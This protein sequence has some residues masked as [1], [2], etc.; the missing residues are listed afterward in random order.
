MTEKIK[1]LV[2]DEGDSLLEVISGKLNFT[3]KI[4]YQKISHV[5]DLVLALDDF[6]PHLI[7]VNEELSS[8]ES[9]SI[10]AIAKKRSSE[11]P[12]IIFFDE[13][14]KIRFVKKQLHNPIPQNFEILLDSLTEIVNNEI[15]KTKTTKGNPGGLNNLM[16]NKFAFIS[17]YLFVLN[18]DNIVESFAKKDSATLTESIKD[19]VGR[20]LE[21]VLDQ[22]FEKKNTFEV[23]YEITMRNKFEKEVWSAKGGGSICYHVRS[24]LLNDRQKIV[25]IN[26]ITKSKN[27]ELMLESRDQIIN[28]LPFAV[29]MLDL[30]DQI[31]NCNEYFAR[32]AASSV[33]TL[34]AKYFEDVI[35]L[36]FNGLSFQEMKKQL[37]ENG[38]WS[39][40]VSIVSGIFKDR[41]S[42]EIFLVKMPVEQITNY[43]ITMMQASG[44]DDKVADVNSFDDYYSIIQQIP[45]GVFVLQNDSVVY[46]NN[47]FAKMLGYSDNDELTSLSF[48]NLLEDN[49]KEKYLE[50]SG[51]I[52]SFEELNH[53]AEFRFV[54]RNGIN[55]VFTNCK[56]SL[57]QHSSGLSIIGM[58]SDLTERKL[59]EEIK[60]GSPEKEFSSE[61][62]LRG[63]AHD[64]RTFLNQI[65]GFADILKEQVKDH[66]DQA[67]LIYAEHIFSSGKKLLDLLEDAP[68]VSE[69]AVL[70]AITPKHE[71]IDV[72]PVLTE[73]IT[74][75]NESL[76]EK[77]IKVSL[78]SDTTVFAIADRRYLIDVLNRIIQNCIAMSSAG[79]ILVDCGYDSIKHNVYIRFKDNRPSIPEDIIEHLFDPVS[80]SALTM[81]EQLRETSITFSIIKRVLD[82]M[83]CKVVVHSSASKGTTI[84]IQLPLDEKNSETVNKGPNVYYTISPDVIYLNDMR[85]YIL[86]IE[87]DPGSS[88]MLEITLKNVARLELAANGKE[89]ITI[90]NSKYEQ[91]IFFD[92]VLI[93]IGLPPP[94]NGITLSHAIKSTFVEYQSIPFI[95]ETAFA[96]EKDREKILSAGFAGFMAKPIDRRYLIKTI[97]SAI[98]KRHGDEEPKYEPYVNPD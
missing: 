86:I 98:R 60:K 32:L 91:G 31:A 57:M 19:Y 62:P 66:P 28:L 16:L 22:F 97:A 27:I 55:R 52:N 54:H 24:I 9:L 69:S 25:S 49:E 8:Y 94:W 50:I 48:V 51:Q 45:E 83:D 41:Y 34:S 23:Q 77:K 37:F 90:I 67:S 70:T 15:G 89:A 96:L 33:E 4:E 88:K 85:P 87:D 7:I 11:I 13:S 74:S 59:A 58:V 73:V 78:L 42:A 29:V 92:V 35:N 6:N 20:R 71:T 18:Q 79:S 84:Y 2:F 38:R 61:N 40:E 12:Y 95:A 47:V 53:T 82:S 46:V 30:D 5:N 72:L 3:G 39:G 75:A 76:A 56:L 63:T 80:E 21:E 1:I 14:K 43:V 68:I 44:G 17:D 10:L 36:K 93:D 65:M 64:Y 81:N 26:D